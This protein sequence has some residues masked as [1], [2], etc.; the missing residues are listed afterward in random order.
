MFHRPALFDGWV[1]EAIVALILPMRPAGVR[2]AC[3]PRPVRIRAGG[4]V[5]TA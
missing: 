5:T 3:V 1:V 4:G 2:S